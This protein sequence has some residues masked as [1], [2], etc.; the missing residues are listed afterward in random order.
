[1]A[2]DIG[3]GG[4]YQPGERI[5]VGGTSTVYAAYDRLTG[6][7]LTVKRILFNGVTSGPASGL[8]PQDLRIVLM[9]EFRTLASLNHPYIIEIYDYGFDADGSAFFTTPY[10]ENTQTLR[11]TA[12]T[13]SFEVCIRLLMQLLQAL[14]HLHQ[15]GIL[16]R[17]LKSESVLVHEGS[18]KIVDFGLSSLAGQHEETH[19]ALAGMAPETIAG[20]I[21]SQPSDLYAVGV[22]AYQ[23]FTGCLPFDAAHGSLINQV[24]NVEP[25]LD[26]PNLPPRLSGWIRRLLGKFPADRFPSAVEALHA[27]SNATGQPLPPETIPIYESSL[28]TPTF[29]GRDHELQQLKEALDSM[30]NGKGS[31]WLVGGETGIGKS[32]LLDELRHYALVK[33]VLVLGGQAV[34]EGSGPYALIHPVLR[35][36]CLLAELEP[37]EAGVL[38]QY[39][40]D[41]EQLLGHPVEDVPELEPG[42][43]QD[44]LIAVIA[45]VFS[46]ASVPILL[47]VEDLQWVKES[48]NVLKRLMRTARQHSLMII[49]SYR[50]DENAALPVQFPG[51][52]VLKLNRLEREQLTA[53]AGSM[54]D[55]PGSLPAWSDRLF[56]QVGGNLF[57]LVELMRELAVVAGGDD[58]MNPA[59]LPE[60]LLTGSMRQLIEHR[61][62]N[63]APV[64]REMLRWAA[65]AG[66]NID[67][68]LLAAAFPGRNLAQWFTECTNVSILESAAGSWRFT[69]DQLREGL[70]AEMTE[71]ERTAMYRQ[72]AQTI[73]KVYPDD[74]DYSTQLLHHWRL[75]GDQ[76]KERF[77]TFK[78]G[79]QAVK[80]RDTRQALGY[81]QRSIALLG[82]DDRPALRAER[83]HILLQLGKAY[84]TLSSFRESETCLR[85]AFA[86]YE[87]LNDRGGISEV[88]SFMGS[89]ARS[90]G[91]YDEAHTC[92]ERSIELA[93]AVGD[94]HKTAVGLNYLG[95][96][97]R[98]QG[99]FE[100]AERCLNESLILLAELADKQ[101]VAMVLNNLG[102]NAR[103]QQRY[104]DARVILFESLDLCLQIGD[105]RSTALNYINLGYVDRMT[106]QFDDARDHFDRSLAIYTDIGD[107][108]GVALATSNLGFVLAE[109]DQLREGYRHMLSAL[110]TFHSIGALPDALMTLVGVGFVKRQLGDLFQ[111]IEL[112]SFALHHPAAN[113]D[114]Q[115]YGRPLLDSACDSLMPDMAE[116]AAERGKQQTVDGWVQILIDE[117]TFGASPGY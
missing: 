11:E 35:W 14:N 61:L 90:Q 62:A 6:S 18:I 28:Q 12:E 81:F 78:A 39:I 68:K 45:G 67:Q 31:F 42:T 30:L 8:S 24:M 16:H 98:T 20:G 102:Y 108:W 15:R 94:I 58:H 5:G 1:M 95:S 77:Y 38:K 34:S 47:I 109:N 40:P 63:L 107:H 100:Q 9:R 32:R 89:L 50:D 48:L 23:L 88:L 21:I 115:T 111:A 82:D 110:Q 96:L 41:I 51:A 79:D 46:R 36:L 97:L 7:S 93:R 44:R 83:A 91:R 54:I 4:R 57:F 117:Q 33:G 56:D 65:L 113:S 13:A 37:L 101:G 76:E 22:L 112:L 71:A 55:A 59:P 105:R 27:L 86:L 72:V 84:R 75:A 73:E 114:I 116:E 85:E 29:T 103:A 43:A 26:N 17:D 70:Q 106:Q 66:R 80:V 52:K 92:L 99:K 87:T 25:V 74:P 69:H 49:G 64:D 10:L 2:Q 60:N 19:S 104:D 53:L 3:I